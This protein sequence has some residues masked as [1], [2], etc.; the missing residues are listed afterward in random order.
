MIMPGVTIGEGAIVAAGSVVTRDVEP[1][2]IVGGVPARPIGR[3]RGP[4][5]YRL[6]FHPLFE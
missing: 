6:A 5:R 4:M 3:R 1:Y 2:T